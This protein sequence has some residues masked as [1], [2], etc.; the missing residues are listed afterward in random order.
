MVKR[1][2]LLLAF[3][4]IISGL[5][6]GQ[7]IGLDSLPAGNKKD[8]VVNYTLPKEKIGSKRRRTDRI[9]SWGLA[10][11]SYNHR[12]IFLPTTFPVRQ[13]IGGHVG[14]SGSGRRHKFGIQIGGSRGKLNREYKV[15]SLLSTPNSDCVG[16]SLNLE[17]GWIWFGK[18]FQKRGIT[19]S[20]YSTNVFI[21]VDRSIV[22]SSKIEVRSFGIAP[23]YDIPIYKSRKAELPKMDICFAPADVFCSI[24]IESYLHY[25]YKIKNL[26]GDNNRRY[27]YGINLSFCFDWSFL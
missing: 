14:I 15:D 3:A 4:F 13:L 27:F 19:I 22:N 24:R 23:F 2:F 17:Y 1:K 21:G 11:V 18:K 12:S 6:K 7:N 10:E 26:A 16:R 5:V 8:T 20:H 25:A 9:Y